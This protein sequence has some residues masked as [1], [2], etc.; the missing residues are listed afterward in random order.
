MD[1]NRFN[2]DGKYSSIKRIDGI[3][4]QEGFEVMLGRVRDSEN[5]N[6]WMPIVSL[7]YEKDGVPTYEHFCSTNCV[8]MFRD[9]AE[10]LQPEIDLGIVTKLAV[11]KTNLRTSQMKLKEILRNTHTD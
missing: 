11:F 9:S 2:F 5:Q 8:G 3:I 7:Y 1:E 10:E 4:P 6:Y